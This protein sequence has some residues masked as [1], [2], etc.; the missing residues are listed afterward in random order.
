MESAIR[1]EEIAIH[2]KAIENA[3]IIVGYPK[4]Q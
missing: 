4:L 2:I 3:D 1:P